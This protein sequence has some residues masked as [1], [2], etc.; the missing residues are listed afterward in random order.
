MIVKILGTGCP[1]CRTLEAKVKEV[2]SQHGIGCEIEKVTDL[3]Q[4]M[5]YGIMITPALVIDEQVKCMGGIP[6]DSQIAQWLRDFIR[7]RVG[8]VHFCL[9][10]AG[11]GHGVPSVPNQ[12]DQSQLAVAGVWSRPRRCHCRGRLAGQL[13]AELPQLDRQLEGNGAGEASLRRAGA[14]GR[15]VFDFHDI[16]IMRKTPSGFRTLTGLSWSKSQCEKP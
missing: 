15:R 4:I 8:A 14:V 10:G 7:Y 11:A 12:C 2:A 1:K 5:S 6:G 13:G 16:I 3:S 9:H